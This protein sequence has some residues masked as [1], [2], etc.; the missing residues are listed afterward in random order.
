MLRDAHCVDLLA[1]RLVICRGPVPKFT[2][3]QSEPNFGR[4]AKR[5]RMALLCHIHTFYDLTVRVKRVGRD[6]QDSELGIHTTIV[7]TRA[8]SLGGTS[9]APNCEQPPV[10]VSREKQTGRCVTSTSF[11]R[12]RI[13]NR[14]FESCR[15]SHR[16]S[17]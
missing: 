9:P 5:K 15:I 7:S 4:S 17:C 6:Q 8:W 11:C 2:R 13:R 10:W 3:R 1:Q 12:A 16:S 14:Q